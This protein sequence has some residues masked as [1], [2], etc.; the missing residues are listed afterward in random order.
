MVDHIERLYADIV[1]AR[2]NDPASC[3]T[4]RLFKSGQVKIG[5]K[6]IEEA[7]EIALAYTAR[8]R[9][10]VVRETANLLYNLTVLLV[11]LDI[12]PEEI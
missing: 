5:K 3:R 9:E 12:S 2:S 4:A 11:E 1:E 6:V 8:D 10:E 7:A